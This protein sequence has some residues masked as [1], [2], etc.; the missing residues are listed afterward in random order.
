MNAN[1]RFREIDIS[2]S[3]HQMG[4]QLGEEAREEIRGFYEI[5]LDRVNLTMRVSE[6]NALAVAA[7][8]LKR[9]EEYSPDVLEELRGVSH[10]SGLSTQELMLL[11]IRNQLQ[12]DRDGACTSFAVS[13]IA[14]NSSIVGQN[15]DNDPAF[16]PFTI[17]LTRRP[18]NEPKFMSIT[19]AG[20]VAY[21]GVNS[22]GIGVCMNTLPAP[23]RML[24][25]PHY[26]TLRGIY[27]STTL[28][29]A[30]EAVHRAKRAI[31]ANLIL[32]TPQGLA[33]F[34]ITMNNVHVIRD[35]GNGIVTHTNHCIHPSLTSV[36]DD[37]P[38]L[39]QSGPRKRRI[40]ELLQNSEK[41]LRLS[42]LQKILCDHE[43]FPYSICRHNNDHPENGFWTSVFSVII[44]VDTREM[45]ISRGN[46]CQNPYETYQLN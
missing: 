17:V 18:D 30:I 25:V 13:S 2:G 1:T 39:I 22:A 15:W 12:P 31:P 7:D 44:N 16:D 19:Q 45:L 14:A 41:P 3:P 10:T 27:Q 35:S 26:F 34:E 37:F 9:V 24:G 6:K 21:I 5:A 42:S 28:D 11:Q 40:D 29:D 23:S 32:V 38:E 8:C 33:D 46:P 43:D 20:L 4:Q 36:N